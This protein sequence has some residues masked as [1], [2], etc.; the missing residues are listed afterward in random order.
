MHFLTERSNTLRALSSTKEFP[1]Y[2]TVRKLL[3]DA[4]C[5]AD[6][7]AARKTVSDLRGQIKENCDGTE[8]LTIWAEAM[9][10]IDR[11]AGEAFGTGLED[12]EDL[13][14]MSIGYLRRL[15]RYRHSVIDTLMDRWLKNGPAET[16]DN[17]ITE[18]FD[19]VIAR[20]AVWLTPIDGDTRAPE[21]LLSGVLM[22]YAWTCFTSMK[23]GIAE[24]S[25]LVSVHS[26][27]SIPRCTLIGPRK[28]SF[29]GA[30]RLNR[31]NMLSAVHIVWIAEF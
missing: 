3:G 26:S 9:D 14:E 17:P 5:G 4:Q 16:Y 1:S 24:V 6:P 12:L 21:P 22:D 10:D 28:Y 30:H 11:H 20:V 27:L 19:R 31:G 25:P 15:S 8:D 2:L 23:E 18:R 7:E 13:S 29:R